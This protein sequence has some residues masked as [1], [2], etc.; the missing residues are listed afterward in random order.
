MNEKSVQGTRSTDKKNSS[1]VF[2][3]G[4]WDMLLIRERDH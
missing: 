2:H 1:L 4:E 3:E